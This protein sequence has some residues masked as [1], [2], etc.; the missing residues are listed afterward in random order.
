MNAPKQ[1]STTLKLSLLKYKQQNLKCMLALYLVFNTE[2]QLRVGNKWDNNYE[3]NY[4]ENY[5]KIWKFGQSKGQTE[6]YRTTFNRGVGGCFFGNRKLR[7]RVRSVPLGFFFTCIK[8]YG[9][10]KVPIPYAKM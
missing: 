3:E 2:C 7:G 4:E 8:V 9:G 1:I 5:E 10:R 6:E